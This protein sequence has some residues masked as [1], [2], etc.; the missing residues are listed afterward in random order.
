M[1]IYLYKNIIS[2]LFSSERFGLYEVDFDSEEKTRTARL[3]ALVYK[4][5][6]QKKIVEEDWQPKSL[7]ITVSKKKK[8]VRDDL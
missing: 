5:I 8:I 3:S 1:F 6:I 7:S 2:S 4:R